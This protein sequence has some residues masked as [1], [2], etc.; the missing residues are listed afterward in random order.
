MV[1]E[2]EPELDLA[3]VRIPGEIAPR[4]AW[5]YLH[6]EQAPFTRSRSTTQTR[7]TRLVRI[8]GRRIEVQYRYESWLQ[9][10]SR[11]PA[12]RVDLAPFCRWLNRREQHGHWIW[13]DTLDIAPAAPHEGGSADV[14][15]T[16]A[17]PARLRPSSRPS[18]PC[19]IRTTGLQDRRSTKHGVTRMSDFCGISCPRAPCRG[20]RLFF[21]VLI[22]SAIQPKDNLT[23]FLEVAP[24][25]I[26]IVV[27]AAT[28]G[29]FPL[30]GSPTSWCWST[31]SS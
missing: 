15:T 27:L 3:I 13:D 8:Q 6:R 16:G 10:A 22:W 18:R 19:G 21:G 4:T 1:V 7:C 12:M 11:R 2:E 31:A 24:A 23:W 26:G 5:R 20:W 17:V 29:S 14:D 25:L 28:R 30:T 9:L